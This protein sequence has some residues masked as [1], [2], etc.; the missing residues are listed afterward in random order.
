MQELALESAPPEGLCDKERR[1]V[2]PTADDADADDSDEVSIVYP[3][4]L[5][6]MFILL[7]LMLSM[8][9]TALD[10]TIISTA[11]PKITADFHSLDDVGWYGSSFFLTMVV[12]QN[13]WGKLYRHLALKPTFLAG[14]TIFELGSL[15]C[16]VSQN[17]TTLIVG[18][19]I[20]GVG[21]SG[22]MSGIYTIIGLSVPPP[23]RAP[24]M[25]VIGA[26]FSVASFTGPLIGGAF[27]SHS[28]WRWCFWINIPIG[29]LVVLLLICCFRTP[30]HARP[31]RISFRKLILSTDPIGMSLVLGALLCFLLALQ[32]G[33]VSKPWS[34][35]DVIGTLVGFGVL[36]IA[37]II[38]EIYQN[39]HGMF[40]ARLLA[41]RRVRVACAYM[42]CFTGCFFPILYYIPIYFQAIDGVSAAQSGIHILPLVLGVG[43]MSIL[44]GVLLQLSGNYPMPLMLVGGILAAVG[45][46]LLYTL[47]QDSSSPQWIGYQALTGI[48]VGLANQIPIVH[49]QAKAKSMTDITSMTSITLFFQFLSGTMMVQAAQA[50]FNNYL[51]RGL[52]KYVPDLDPSAVIDIDIVLSGL[53][54]ILAL[55]IGMKQLNVQPGA[56]IAA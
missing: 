35:P 53:A 8:F 36:T 4:G 44:G 27:T 3:N 14:I 5:R 7:C 29:A 30:S 42:F 43:L 28:T 20:T 51:V 52:V 33:G 50:I 24:Y 2:A 17:S 22:L 25:G 1:A 48:G 13:L 41:D 15:V 6:M 11:I 34:H 37:F 54:T 46:G 21:G 31:E 38:N 19:A 26:T 45:S 49:N 23:R 18:R 16:A 9:L 40:P 32:W 56:A 39:E 10:T 12:T 55:G 47:D